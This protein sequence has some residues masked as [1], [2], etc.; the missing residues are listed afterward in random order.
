MFILSTGSVLWQIQ[1]FGSR[2]HKSKTGEKAAQQQ[3]SWM[4]HDLIHLA[5]KHEHTFA[6]LCKFDPNAAVP[7]QKNHSRS[8]ILNTSWYFYHLKCPSM[9]KWFQIWLCEPVH[10]RTKPG[11][12]WVLGRCWQWRC[13]L[14]GC[15]GCCLIL[16]QEKNPGLYDRRLFE[17]THQNSSICSFKNWLAMTYPA[18]GSSSNRNLQFCPPVTPQELNAITVDEI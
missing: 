1:W 5:E 15:Y 14:R 8:A 4:C 9:S 16:L 18:C 11:K 3:E 6:I 7:T 2:S 12:I 17:H 13:C 10:A